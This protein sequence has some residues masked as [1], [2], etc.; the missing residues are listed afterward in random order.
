M[1][2]AFNKAAGLDYS[3][4]LSVNSLDEE[5]LHKARD[6]F[7][8]YYE[9]GIIIKG[10]FDD[11]NWQVTDEKSCTW[12]RFGYDDSIYEA[13][14]Q[15]WIG[16][17]TDCYRETIKAYVVFLMG[18]RTLP[19]LRELASRFR[20][21]ASMD[22]PEGQGF[23]EDSGHVAEMLRLIPG[24]YTER[25]SAIE[26]LEDCYRNYVKKMGNQR[27]LLD[28]PAYFRFHDLFTEFWENADDNKRLYYFPLFL[29]WNLT[30]VL[31]LRVTEFL[32][33]P[34]NCI[35]QTGDEFIITVRRT[36]LKGSDKRMAYKVDE[37]YEKKN[38]PVSK[39]VA[40]MILWY[41]GKAGKEEKSPID[42]LF[43]MGPYKSR[44]KDAVQDIF[45]YDCLRHM[46]T[47]LYRYELPE[48]APMV[49]FG[50]TRHIAMM[51]LIIS[52]GSPRMCMELAGHANIGIS[53]H[54]YSNMTAL[55]ECATYELYRKSKQGTGARVSGKRF[56]SLEST[57][58]M[59]RL[60]NGWC[61]SEKRKAFQVD[62]CIL[63]V[64]SLGEIGDCKSCR[65]FRGDVQ[66][67][68][69]DF[70]DSTHGKNKVLSDC[71]FLMKMFDAVRQGIGC[72]EDIK[73]ALLRLQTSCNHYRE[74]LWK[75]YE[76]KE[77]GETE[78]TQ[79]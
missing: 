22:Y 65:Y 26:F 32:M 49:H 14:A 21:V 29:W 52:G 64:N 58:N 31:P 6:I 57:E 38:Y 63:A 72:Q 70:F 69:I 78:K 77:H 34:E 60:K 76:V 51:N 75:E 56:Y 20:E 36:S 68:Q 30:A 17:T 46:K 71:W 3:R 33:I 45:N 2:T 40:K 12:I 9:H 54:Y 15:E 4:Y 39:R 5:T 10:S 53:S 11:D 23:K 55:I 7:Q 67:N 66:G 44:R 16:C 41:K 27:K 73:Q 61:S 24:E 35:T 79:Q 62:D 18:S 50:D 74:C 8:Y 28:F 42:V 48:D 59:V 47:D 25:E 13:H 1:I 37:D 43:R 19:A